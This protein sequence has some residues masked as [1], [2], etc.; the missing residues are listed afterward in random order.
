M[1]T[2]SGI[3]IA[4]ATYQVPALMTQIYIY[5]GAVVV[6]GVGVRLALLHFTKIF[7]ED[8]I[9]LANIN[10]KIRHTFYA[11]IIMMS[12]ATFS[13]WAEDMF[14]HGDGPIDRNDRDTETGDQR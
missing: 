2:M 9:G 5:G 10:K 13:Y 11:G 1:Q 7:Y 3:L 8:D 12:L 6:M 4:S 14:K